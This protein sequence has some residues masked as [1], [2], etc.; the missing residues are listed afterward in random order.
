MTNKI[1]IASTT[2][3]DTGWEF[4]IKVDDHSYR[5]TLSNEYHHQLTGGE[6]TPQTLTLQS[7]VFLLAR[8]PADSI[9][10]QFDLERINDYFPEFESEIV[11]QLR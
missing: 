7:F 2:E 5:V 6:V 1:M 10:G 9:L 4:E 3:S 8:E 11:K